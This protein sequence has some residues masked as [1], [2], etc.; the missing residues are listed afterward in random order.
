MDGLFQHG[1]PKLVCSKIWIMVHLPKIKIG[2]GLTPRPI[3]SRI[4]VFSKLRSWFNPLAQEDGYVDNLH[5]S[6]L[7]P[8]IFH[9][10]IYVHAWEES[11]LQYL[12][13][14]ISNSLECR[15]CLLVATTPQ[16]H[17]NMWNVH[18]MLWLMAGSCSFSMYGASNDNVLRFLLQ[19]RPHHSLFTVS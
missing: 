18:V 16:Y 7:H 4:I 6:S 9:S 19:R 5:S 11:K 8:G 12:V 15:D 14:D 17:N 3:Q 13:L 1:T 2:Y 10:R